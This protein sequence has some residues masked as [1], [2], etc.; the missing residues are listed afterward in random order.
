MRRGLVQQRREVNFLSAGRDGITEG[1]VA[2]FDVRREEPRR[3]RRQAAT[4]N[5]LAMKVAWAGMSLAGM[6]ATCPL[7]TIARIS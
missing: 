4:P 1:S 5:R 3:P 6:A 7:R 2:K